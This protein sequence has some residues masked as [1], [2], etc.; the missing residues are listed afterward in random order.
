MSVPSWVDHTIWWHVYPLGAVGAPIRE[1]DAHPGPR[2]RHLLDWLDHTI[3][4]GTNG[5][6]LGPVF[7]STSHG[8]DTTDF[9]RLDT[10]LGDDADLD[11]LIAQCRRRGLRVLL[12]GVFSHV[13]YEHPMVAQA[14]RGGP[15]SETGRL[16][17]IDWDADGGPA[18]RVFEGH[19]SLVRIKH[20]EP[21]AVDLAVTVMTHWL[22]RGIDGWRLDA[23]YSVP[24]TFWA[25]ALSRVRERHPDAWFLGEVIHGDYAAFV[26]TSTADS[27]TQYELW[28]AIWSSLLDG[29]FYELA[30]A[31]GRHD[32]MLADFTP[33]TFVGNHDVTRIAT[34]VGSERALLALAVLM[35]VGGIPSIYYGDELGW[36][37]TKEERI[38][39]D[40]AVRP[41]LPSASAALGDAAAE[42]ALDAH[43]AL[44]ALRRRHPWLTTARTEV[45]ELSNERIVYRSVGASGEILTTELD[46]TGTPTAVVTA[47]GATEWRLPG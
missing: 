12:D 42:P 33:N 4:L 45:V 15:D 13:G 22:D 39:G 1:P 46:V 14:L 11:E 19:G 2:L 18:P 9:F 40:D 10:R 29:N 6:L 44:V 23:A 31:L 27:V 30:H 37:G 36:R 8:Y 26:A 32:T 43:R 35:T 24:A 25:A 28:K 7:A 3:E 20:D 38:G 21:A 34:T 16:L 17:D 5:L 47:D 41:P